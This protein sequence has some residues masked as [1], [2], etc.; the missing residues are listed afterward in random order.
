MHRH[1]TLPSSGRHKARCARFAPPLMSNV[2]SRLSRYLTRCAGQ[3]PSSFS[4][5][6]ERHERQQEAVQAQAVSCASAAKHEA[7]PGQ[8][9]RW[10]SAH[11]R[12]FGSQFSRHGRPRRRASVQVG[13]SV[14]ADGQI[15]S[16]GLRVGRRQACVA[17]LGLANSRY[18]TLV[19]VGCRRAKAV[20]FCG[21]RL[22]SF[23]T[24]PDGT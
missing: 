14:P 16:A 9:V 24:L 20:R 4:P 3:R 21:L 22:S 10:R 5:G 6:L 19:V 2:R 8:P 1:L 17:S 7:L 18:E 12:C 11:R 23:Q 13:C 15:R